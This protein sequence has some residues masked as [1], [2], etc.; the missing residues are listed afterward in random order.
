MPTFQQYIKNHRI[1][2]KFR[3]STPHFHG[4]P[5]KYGVCLRVGTVKPKKPNSA[6]RKIA[7]VSLSNKRQ[8]IAY[9]PGMGHN[10]QKHSSVMVRGGRVPDLPGCRYH[11]MRGK[12]DFHMSETF[13]RKNR[14]SK[15]AK[16]NPIKQQ[17]HHK[18]FQ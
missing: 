13:D 4:A 10:L 16:K 17:K 18:E 6:Q 7:K 1:V 15:F 8:L 3:S 12:V 11:I 14:R 2:K 9:I 5:H